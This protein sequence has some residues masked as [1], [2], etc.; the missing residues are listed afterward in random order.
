MTAYRYIVEQIRI[1][2][3]DYPPD[4]VKVCAQRLGISSARVSSATVV[5]RSIDARRRPVLV[6]SCMV[7][8]D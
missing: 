3:E 7:E 4:I 6:L 5:R 8:V 1:A 2:P